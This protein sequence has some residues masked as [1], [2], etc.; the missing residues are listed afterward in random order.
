MSDAFA[1]VDCNN[2]YVSVERVFNPKLLGK[3]IVVLSNNDGCV[4]SRSDEAKQIGIRMGAPLF[5]VQSLVDADKVEIFSSNYELYGD[6][7]ARLMGTLREFTPDIEVYSIDEAFLG[8]D[9]KS[10]NLNEVG[11]AVQQKVKKW[12]GLPTSI[13]IA[14]TKT[15]AKLANHIARKSEKARGVLNLYNSPYTKEALKRTGVGD[16]WGISRKTVEKLLRH[17]VKTAFDLSSMDLRQA[18]KI[19]SVVGARIV[20]ELRGVSC[21]SL[22]TIKPKKHSITCSRS[23][24]RAIENYALLREAVAVFVARAAE[25]LRKQ[26]LAAKTV[27]VFIAADRFQSEYYSSHFAHSSV[28]P[29]DTNFELQKQAF[30]CLDEIFRKGIFY[31]KAGVILSDLSPADELTGRLFDEKKWERFRRV[32][33][34][35][36]E[37]NRRFGRDKIHGAAAKPKGVWQGKCAHRSNRYTTRFDEILTVT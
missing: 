32:T 17:N 25:K 13:G 7:S 10:E 2:F 29:S 28:Y 24:G 4:I 31:R 27:T 21:L 36:D 19:L 9:A 5:K 18:R 14:E 26:N 1:L 11:F 34:A 20:L 3:P 35:V 16:V 8:F 37:I 30:L 6:M 15:L 22:E 23:F 33:K 12:T